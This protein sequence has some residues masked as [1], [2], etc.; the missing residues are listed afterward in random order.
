[1]DILF[2]VG[3]VIFGLVL[4]STESLEDVKKDFGVK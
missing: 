1:M 2:F 4:L 3:M